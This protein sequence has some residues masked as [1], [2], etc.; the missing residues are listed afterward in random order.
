MHPIELATQLVADGLDIALAKGHVTSEELAALRAFVEPL[1][2][3][4]IRAIAG[5]QGRWLPE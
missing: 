3:T 1:G 4:D 2:I 5:A